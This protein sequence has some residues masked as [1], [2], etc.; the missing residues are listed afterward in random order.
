MRKWSGE[1][2]NSLCWNAISATLFL[3]LFRPF[4]CSLRKQPWPLLSGTVLTWSDLSFLLG[5]TYMLFRTSITIWTWKSMVTKLTLDP[6]HG[7]IQALSLSFHCYLS[8]SYLVHV[9]SHLTS[10]PRACIFPTANKKCCQLWNLSHLIK[11]VV[12]ACSERAGGGICRCV[13]FSWQ[14]TCPMGISKV[15]YPEQ[16]VFPLRLVL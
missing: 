13:G 9:S 6:G 10:L 1:Q 2:F 4:V 11:N 12:T 5:N 8:Q 14:P 16:W 7:Q 3:W 15:F